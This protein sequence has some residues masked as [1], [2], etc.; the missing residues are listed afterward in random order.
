MSIKSSKIETMKITSDQDNQIIFELGS[1]KG[2]GKFQM[3]SSLNEAEKIAL[4]ILN[5]VNAVKES[6]R[7][8]LRFCHL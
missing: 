5:E 3:L 8:K 2:E 4:Q 6:K 1:E 7:Q